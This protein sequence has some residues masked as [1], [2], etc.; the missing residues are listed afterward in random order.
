M[1][2]DFA[3]EGADRVTQVL[4]FAADRAWLSLALLVATMIAVSSAV[5]LVTRHAYRKQMERLAE[6][7]AQQTTHTG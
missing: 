5:F 6:Q 4:Q 2:P 1:S 3:I 7:L